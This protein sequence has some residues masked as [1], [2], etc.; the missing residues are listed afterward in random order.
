MTMMK[1]TL[2]KTLGYRTDMMATVPKKRKSF[3]EASVPMAVCVYQTHTLRIT[4]MHAVSKLNGETALN[5]TA[6]LTRGLSSEKA[7]LKYYTLVPEEHRVDKYIHSQHALAYYR[8]CLV[9]ARNE[10]GQCASG[11][12]SV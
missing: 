8:S 9:A 4:K 10:P 5:R 1:Y 11:I 6:P 12:F 2:K 3:W 7:R